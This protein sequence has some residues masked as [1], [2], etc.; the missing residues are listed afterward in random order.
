VTQRGQ[1]CAEVIVPVDQLVRKADDE[2]ERA[3]SPVS[4]GL[5]LDLYAVGFRLCRDLP[6]IGFVRKGR[7]LVLHP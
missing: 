6:L 5:V 7:F 1:V 3:T 2:K 4:R